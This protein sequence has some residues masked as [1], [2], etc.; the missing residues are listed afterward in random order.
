M[1]AQMRSVRPLTAVFL[2][3]LV[4]AVGVVFGGCGAGDVSSNTS[5]VVQVTRAAYV[6]SQ[7]PGF[8]MAMTMSADIGGEPF[9]LSTDGAFDEHGRRGTMSET[10]SGKTVTTILDLPYGYLQSKGKLIKGKP[11]ARFNIEGYTQSLGVSGSLNTSGDP[12]QWIDFLKAAGQAST[13]GHQTLRGVPTTHYHALVDFARFPAVVPARLRAGAQE[14]AALLKRISGQSNLPIDVWIDGHNQVRRYQLQIPLC[15]QG[16]RTSESMSIELYD[17]GTQSIPAPPPL[18]EVSDLT[19]E[20]DSNAS[21][22][23]QQ[24]HC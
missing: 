13:V 11:W 2:V 15:Y 18:S 6:T 22:A 23:L 24:L 14:Q 20:V 16:E 7:G 4:G 10:V 21:R 1:H 5:A 17:Y 12:S 19:N 3:A 9:S 8:R